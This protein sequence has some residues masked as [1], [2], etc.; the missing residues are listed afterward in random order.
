MTEQDEV[1][2]QSIGRLATGEDAEDRVG[3]NSGGATQ[4]QMMNSSA[5]KWPSAQP[6]ALFYNL[7]SRLSATNARAGP[8]R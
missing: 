7:T 1:E 2:Q 4:R 5:S 6:A 8:W 3:D